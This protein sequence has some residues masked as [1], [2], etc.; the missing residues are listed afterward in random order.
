MDQTSLNQCADLAYRKSDTELNSLYKEVVLRLKDDSQAGKLLVAAQRA[1]IS[2]RDAECAFSSAG[3]IGGSIH[4]LIY[5]GCLG[6]LTKT[7][8]DDLKRFLKCEE[9]DLSCPVP[10]EK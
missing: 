10:A 3:N 4:P 7:R 9:G 6:R 2:F 5:S 8:I 1:W